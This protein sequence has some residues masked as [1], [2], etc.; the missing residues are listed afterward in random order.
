MQNDR[1]AYGPLEA[2]R[3]IGVSKT[4]MYEMLHAGEIKARR[5]GRRWIVPR[6][7]LEEYLEGAVG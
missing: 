4:I 3:M 6:S 7:A 5:Q 1:L 2:A